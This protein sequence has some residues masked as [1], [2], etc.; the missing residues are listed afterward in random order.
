M[1]DRK[2]IEDAF[3]K[4][5]VDVKIAKTVFSSYSC[6]IYVATLVPDEEELTLE[7]IQKIQNDMA[8]ELG[9]TPY[10]RPLLTFCNIM[11]YMRNDSPTVLPYSGRQ[12]T[13]RFRE[14]YVSP[15]SVGRDEDGTLFT[16]DFNDNPTL[17]ITGEDGYGKSN[18]IRVIMKSAAKYD[19]YRFIVAD[20]SGDGGYEK[21]PSCS[22]I[23][24]KDELFAAL[25]DLQSEIRRRTEFCRE[26]RKTKHILSEK[27]KKSLRSIVLFI[28]DYSSLELSEKEKR[29]LLKTV[30]A[31]RRSGIN[32]CV[33]LVL[34]SQ[35]IPDFVK[36]NVGELFPGVITLR[37]KDDESTILNQ[38]C[39]LPLPVYYPG[40]A[41]YLD[42]EDKTTFR[43]QCFRL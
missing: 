35:S 39:E 7:L 11:I 16:L 24:T 32:N 33:Y 42:N 41:F 21:S 3:Q 28:D 6:S 19:R 22:V 34:A 29:S 26:W 38:T 5:G 18:L 37:M 15:F 17:L 27:E 10:F 12:L 4:N 43:I 25:S 20:V 8:H 30:K 23:R 40:D 2:T 36:E 1:D 14:N 31:I 13:P 9:Y